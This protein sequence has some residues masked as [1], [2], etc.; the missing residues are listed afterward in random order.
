MNRSEALEGVRLPDV[1]W[2]FEEAQG[3]TPEE[4]GRVYISHRDAA[5]HLGGLAEI[6]SQ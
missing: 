4:K 6:Y 1:A 5:L 2:R 3:N